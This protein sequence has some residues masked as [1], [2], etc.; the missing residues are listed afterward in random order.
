MEEGRQKSGRLSYMAEFKHQVVWCMEEKVNCK[1][2][3][4]FRVDES[5]I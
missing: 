4:I 5:N 2:P 1:A 3:D